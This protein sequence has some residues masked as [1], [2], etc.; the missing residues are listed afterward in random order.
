MIF[1]EVRVG[2]MGQ[3]PSPHAHTLQHTLELNFTQVIT[4]GGGGR[5]EVEEKF[6]RSMDIK[7]LQSTNEVTTNAYTHKKCFA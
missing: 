3:R 6:Q 1:D 2:A 5:G 4:K 7:G